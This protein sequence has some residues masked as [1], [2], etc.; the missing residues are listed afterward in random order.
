MTFS[1]I[2]VY[3]RDLKRIKFHHNIDLFEIKAQANFVSQYGNA[4]RTS[5][6]ASSPPCQHQRTALPEISCSLNVFFY[7]ISLQYLQSLRCSPLYQCW[8]AERSY[9]LKVI[10][11]V[12][13]DIDQIA[14]VSTVIIAN[15]CKFI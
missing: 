7:W 5:P 14:Q 12:W 9:C 4:A 8:H 13:F 11:A 3:S 15:I 2:I 10:M 6:Q 1:K